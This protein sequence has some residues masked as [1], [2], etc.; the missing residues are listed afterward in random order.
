MF[1]SHPKPWANI[2]ARPPCPSTRT[3]LRVRA[4]T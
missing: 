3:L 2:I 1:W 4:A